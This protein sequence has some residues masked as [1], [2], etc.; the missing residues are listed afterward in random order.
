MLP[1]RHGG[2][3]ADRHGRR[4]LMNDPVLAALYRSKS[5][6]WDVTEALF[7]WA[8]SSMLAL[9]LLPR[10]DPAV[11]FAWGAVFLVVIS[12]LVVSIATIRRLRRLIRERI[13]G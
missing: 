2:V 13:G 7:V 10:T 1:D 12:C 11:M 8:V 9:A 4:D 6:A 3:L 5:R